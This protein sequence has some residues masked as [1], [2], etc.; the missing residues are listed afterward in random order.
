MFV[1]YLGD[2]RLI[3]TA[4]SSSLK[5]KICTSLQHFREEAVVKDGVTRYMVRRIPG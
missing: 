4:C 1:T 5:P 3:S 2:T